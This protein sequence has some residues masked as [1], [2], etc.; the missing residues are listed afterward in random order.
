MTASVNAVI[1]ATGGFDR[2][3]RLHE[4]FLPAAATATGAVPCNRGDALRIAEGLG[5]VLENTAQAWWMPMMSVPGETIDG[6]PYYR[7]L[8][9]ERALP[10]QIIVNERGRRFADEALPY[11]EFVKAMLARARTA[12]MIFDEGYRQRFP[13]PG[14]G[15]GD[16]LPRWVVSAASLA[17][18]AAAIEIPAAEFSATVARW[19]A[20]CATGTDP[21]FGRGGNAYERYMGD[22]DTAPSPNLGPVDRPPFYAIRVL[23]GTI[24]TKGGPVTDTNARVLRDDGT[25]VT[26][27][28]AV[29]NAAAFWTSEGYPGPGATLGIAMTMGYLAG[30]DAAARAYSLPHPPRLPVLAA[31]IPPPYRHVTKRRWATPRGQPGLRKP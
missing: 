9:R 11:N 2:D 3:T 31:A 7:S 25:P 4:R 24:G 18:L 23:P 12:W 21:D 26:G 15:L 10:R 22:P 8:I 19:N 27:L 30:R 17:E 14:A 6:E 29:G 20:N 1:M 16:L 5:A 28:Y 13:V